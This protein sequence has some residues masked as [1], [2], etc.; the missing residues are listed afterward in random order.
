[1]LKYLTIL[2]LSLGFLALAEFIYYRPSSDRSSDFEEQHKKS[3][4]ADYEILEYR[5]LPPP[6][7][8]LR[9]ITDRP[10][11]TRTRRPA[12]L[13]VQ[14]PIETFR[15]HGVMLT[16]RHN[17]ALVERRSDGVLLRLRE[18]DHVDGWQIAFI[19]ADAI[20]FSGSGDSYAIKIS[21]TVED[22]LDHDSVERIIAEEE[23]I[24]SEIDDVDTG[25]EVNPLWP[26]RA[27]GDQEFNRRL[28]PR[29]VSK[30]TERRDISDPTTSPVELPPPPPHPLL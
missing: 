28:R 23:H 17:T 16:N 2:C 24:G 18:G 15:L 27:S 3:D 30:A 7:A 12:E 26:V 6:I 22:R 21:D 13:I 19:D 1:M 5:F 25:N 14:S 11:F 4:Y 29:S 9:E 20:G 8:H 10:L